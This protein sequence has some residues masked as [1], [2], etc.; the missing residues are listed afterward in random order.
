[1]GEGVRRL[2]ELLPHSE[3]KVYPNARHSLAA[4]VPGALA[5]AIEE[6]LMRPA[7]ELP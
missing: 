1:M 3:L 5:A 4:E 6:F 7:H 2:H